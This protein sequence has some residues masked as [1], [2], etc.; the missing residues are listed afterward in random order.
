MWKSQYLCITQ[1]V[2]QKPKLSES[3]FLS[4]GESLLCQVASPSSGTYAGS[5]LRSLVALVRTEGSPSVRPLALRTPWAPVW[6]HG[7]VPRQPRVRTGTPT[8]RCQAH[9]GVVTCPW[10]CD[11]PASRRLSFEASNQ[12]TVTAVHFVKHQITDP[13]H[14]WPESSDVFACFVRVV[15][16]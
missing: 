12:N 8:P 16:Y 3:Q 4:L 6:G 10:C 9:G 1:L 13:E 14:S 5:V 11:S 2:F 7:L 15:G